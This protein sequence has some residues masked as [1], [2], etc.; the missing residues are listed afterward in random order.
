[1]NFGI[2]ELF[3]LLGNVP[4]DFYFIVYIVYGGLIVL[5]FDELL[6]FMRSLLGR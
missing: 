3:K 1:M 4:E 2:D 6:H 5:L